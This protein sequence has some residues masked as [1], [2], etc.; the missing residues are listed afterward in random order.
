MHVLLVIGRKKIVEA[1]KIIVTQIRVSLLIKLCQDNLLQL[2][3]KRKIKLA[4]NSF[5]ATLD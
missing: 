4:L 1:A 2:L 3:V 5:L